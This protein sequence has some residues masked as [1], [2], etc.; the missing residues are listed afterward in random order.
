MV[1]RVAVWLTMVLIVIVVVMASF[2]RLAPAGSE[3]QEFGQSFFDFLG[4]ITPGD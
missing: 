3:L 1:L 2:A 4:R